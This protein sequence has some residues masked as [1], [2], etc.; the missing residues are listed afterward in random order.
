[1]VEWYHVEETGILARYVIVSG[2]LLG[3]L[4][5]K[6]SVTICNSKV[7][8]AKRQLFFVRVTISYSVGRHG[9]LQFSGAIS[10][11][12]WIKSESGAFRKVTRKAE[13]ILVP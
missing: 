4:F 6:R 11:K 13:N 8:S 3:C 12:R 7:F 2:W 10:W 5:L 9:L 1:M